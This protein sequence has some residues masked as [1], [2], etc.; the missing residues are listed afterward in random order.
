MFTGRSC[1]EQARA[2]RLAGGGRAVGLEGLA[3]GRV[4]VGRDL[5]LVEPRVV[6]DPTLRDL[7]WLPRVIERANLVSEVL[8]MRVAR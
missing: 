7:P 4:E 8:E 2:E 6:V 5:H 1:L 3:S